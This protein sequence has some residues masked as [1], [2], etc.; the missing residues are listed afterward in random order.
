MS[1]LPSRALTV[2]GTGR[3]VSSTSDSK[4][5]VSSSTATRPSGS[6]TRDRGRLV[7]ARPL[8]DERLAAGRGCHRVVAGLGCEDLGPRGRAVERSAGEGTQVG[9]DGRIQARRREVDRAR[10]L[11]DVHEVSHHP[12]A[13]GD[14]ADEIAVAAVQ[15]E[16]RPA[17]TLRVPE[18]LAALEHP[19]VGLARA[20]QEDGL[21]MVSG[22]LGHQRA[23]GAGRSV[24]L[25]EPHRA[26]AARPAQQVRLRTVVVPPELTQVGQRHERRVDPLGLDR[27][28]RAAPGV[29]RA[30]TRSRARP[31]HRGSACGR[32]CRT[33]RALSPRSVVCRTCISPTSRWSR[34]AVR[35]VLPSG[36]HSAEG[37]STMPARFSVI[38]E[39]RASGREA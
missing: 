22:G 27:P 12:G 28:H 33:G 14:L 34:R 1:V 30:A 16:V 6:R 29:R 11:V 24:D 18:H 2:K 3:P 38:V 26:R 10:R 20:D 19:D 8:V 21:D 25:L 7:D 13:P 36:D 39:R 9:I 5:A 15:V 35:A 23:C 17:V 37:G 31:R 32:V 4:S